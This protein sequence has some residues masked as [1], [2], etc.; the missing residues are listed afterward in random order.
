MVQNNNILSV[1]S[2]KNRQN[3]DSPC[4]KHLIGKVNPISICLYIASEGDFNI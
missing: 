4:L 3:C 2:L 1:S